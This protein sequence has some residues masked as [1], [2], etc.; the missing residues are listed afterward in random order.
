MYDDHDC[1]QIIHCD[2][3]FDSIECFNNY[4]FD[5]VPNHEVQTTPNHWHTQL[6]H[7]IVYT[8]FL[9]FLQR[10]AESLQCWFV[11]VE[12]FGYLKT[13]VCV[14]KM[15]DMNVCRVLKSDSFELS[16]PS[17]F[18]YKLTILQPIS[19]FLVPLVFIFE[20]PFR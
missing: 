12:G 11:E 17:F 4:W 6:F 8:V 15:R 16:P 18:C 19:N 10:K 5:S 20:C 14:C 7:I 2:V 9:H 1:L 3:N 13:F